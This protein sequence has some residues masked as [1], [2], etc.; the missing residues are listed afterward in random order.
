MGSSVV[1]NTSQQCKMLV[2]GA[3]AWEG[4]QELSVLSVQFLCKSKTALKILI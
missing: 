2:T 4:I 1:T 3:P